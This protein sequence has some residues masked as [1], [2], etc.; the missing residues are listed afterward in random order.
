[1]NDR[2]IHS[3]AVFC[4]LQLMRDRFFFSFFEFLVTQFSR[5]NNGDGWLAFFQRK[6]HQRLSFFSFSFVVFVVTEKSRLAVKITHAYPFAIS[7][8]TLLCKARKKWTSFVLSAFIFCLDVVSFL[9]PWNIFAFHFLPFF[10]TW[11]HLVFVLRFFRGSKVKSGE[12][13]RFLRDECQRE[14]LGYNTH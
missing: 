8:V 9:F 10:L 6:Q 7:C 4:Q 14:C 1:M 2:S 5:V 13:D 3:H 11:K 12:S